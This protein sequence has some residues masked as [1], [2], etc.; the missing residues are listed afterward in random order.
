MTT[1]AAARKIR[2]ASFLRFLIL[3]CHITVSQQSETVVAV[4][5][6]PGDDEA[7]TEVE[8][9][10]AM[11][12]LG[13]LV[14]EVDA[15]LD[16]EVQI[17]DSEKDYV[18]PSSPVPQHSAI[19]IDESIIVESLDEDGIIGNEQQQHP[20]LQ[21]TPPTHFQIT[22]HI[23]TNLHTGYSYFL[24]K[25]L[26]S[27]SLAHLPYLECGA[28]GSTTESLPLVSGVFRH[29]PHTSSLP[30]REES[31]V[32]NVVL[33]TME[34]KL[35]EGKDEVLMDGLDMLLNQD[36]EATSSV[37]ET[38]DHD[39]TTDSA[40]ERSNEHPK[41]PS[42]PKYVVVLSP[43]EITV[44]GN[45]NETQKFDAGDVIFIEGT[46]WGVWD[47]DGEAD[48]E[49]ILH[50]NESSSEDATDGMNGDEAKM[51]GY[52]MHA[53]SESEV[54]LNV[55]ML[56]IPN[57]I[58]RQ[59]KMAQYSLAMAQREEREMRQQLLN[60]NNLFEREMQQRAWW[61]LPKLSYSKNQ[62]RQQPEL[63]K[64]CG[65]E[66][67][68]AFV[69]PSAI[70]SATLSQHFARHFTTL[71][72]RSTNPFTSFLPNHHHHHHQELL[73]PILLQTT[74]AVI[75]GVTSLGVVLQLW[76]LIPGPIAVFFGSA[77]FVGFGTWGFVWLGEEILDQVE[78][79]SERRRFEKMIV[80]GRNKD[81][82]VVEG[83][84]PNRFVA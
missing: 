16:T 8:D 20:Q 15:V 53:S 14:D 74:A 78:L 39:E 54:D 61:K 41:R 24:P 12:M 36:D 38:M 6:V 56:T 69:H 3:L 19:V 70:S 64:P 52:I 80:R 68:P 29:V 22:A 43:L 17:T 32:M 13:S 55:L 65:L 63:P 66:S 82:E 49:T 50:E 60:T 40:G 83:A 34:E 11:L 76:R 37:N 44:G 31:T 46:W 27:T 58:H 51:K 72:R 84:S 9:I 30:K 23:Q 35:Q 26:L 48:S 73:L 1:T 18:G 33:E 57:A 42:P 45:G 4:P 5:G 62:Y 59:W 67:D 75:G 7:E 28:I 47:V 77:C 71:L 79:W 21:Y 25:E 10:V 81:R 2:S